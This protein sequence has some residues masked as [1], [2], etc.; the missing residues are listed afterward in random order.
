METHVIAS[1]LATSAEVW[2]AIEKIAKE[3]S[4]NKKIEL[5][6]EMHDKGNT[7]FMWVLKMVFDNTVNFGI[8]I[9]KHELHDLTTWGTPKPFTADVSRFLTWLAAGSYTRAEALYRAKNLA[10]NLDEESA[11]LLVAIINKNINAGINASTINKVWKGLIPSFPYMRCSIPSYY[12]LTMMEWRAGVYAQEK[13]DGMF[14]NI[15][16]RTDGVTLLS[17]QGTV[18]PTDKLNGVADDLALVLPAGNQVH[19]EMLLKDPDGKIAAR[20]IGNGILN[21]VCK[22][23]NIPDGWKIL[24][25]VWDAIPLA[26]VEPHGKYTEPYKTRFDEL[27]NYLKKAIFRYSQEGRH[28]DCIETIETKICFNKAQAMSFY[29]NMLASG[30]EGVVLKNPTAIW[31]D[32]TSKEQIKMKLV[33]DCDLKIVGFE[34]GKGKFEGTLGSVI[35]ESSD[36]MLRTNVSGFNDKTRREVWDNRDD[37]LGKIITIKFNDVMQKEGQISSL[38]LP[39]FVEFRNDKTEPDSYNRVLDSMN[40]AISGYF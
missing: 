28:I 26:A 17:R 33:C 1:D 40:R 11:K 10:V 24:F 34:E 5:L 12:D 30:K 7:L 18:I 14:V 23:G 2:N 3:P 6:K 15:N 4:R 25:R 37:Y 22:G 19:G 39:R 32:G 8:V 13:A 36:G 20:E 38:F 35:C 16:V 9:K 31:K 21:S 27:S 29:R